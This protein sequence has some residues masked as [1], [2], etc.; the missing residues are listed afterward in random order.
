MHH[1]VFT[2][3]PQDLKSDS[4]N[5]MSFIIFQISEFG[6]QLRNIP[7]VDNFFHFS[8][9]FCLEMH[10]VCRGVSCLV[11]PESNRVNTQQISAISDF[12]TDISGTT[13]TSAS[14]TDGDYFHVKTPVQRELR[15]PVSHCFGKNNQANNQDC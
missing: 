6:G 5:R 2:L 15:S 8:S 4:P 9:R 10:G 3:H 12:D 13:V 11:I 1:M 14:E 7:L